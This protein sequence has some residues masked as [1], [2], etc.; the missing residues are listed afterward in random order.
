MDLAQR[1][2]EFAAAIKITTEHQ[3][4]DVTSIEATPNL[5]LQF[6]GT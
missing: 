6:G 1:R 5:L 4:I 3:L 2:F